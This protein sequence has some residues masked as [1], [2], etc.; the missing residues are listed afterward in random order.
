MQVRHLRMAGIAVLALANV[1][2]WSNSSVEE[3]AFPSMV[4]EVVTLRLVPGGRI[5]VHVSYEVEGD[6]RSE[7]EMV[8]PETEWFPLEQ[9]RARWNGIDLPV[10]R[11]PA[12]ADAYYSYRDH[13]F[14]AV[15]R[16]TVPPTESTVGRKAHRLENEYEY[17]PPYYGP[18]SK[19]DGPEGR[20]V[21]YI[22]VTGSTWRGPIGSVKVVFHTGCIPCEKISVLPGSY[23]GA[24]TGKNT[25][26][27]HAKNIAPDRDVRLLLPLADY[28]SH[29][30]KA[31]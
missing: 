12:P 7:R 14:T 6:V 1:L 20:Y 3:T 21:E 26:E 16:F 4:G 8:F 24:C 10:V 11:V 2:F 15:Y 25:W 23:G 29:T 28:H 30:F 22:L 19:S 9:F 13:R 18:G 17:V 5:R 27:F 31:R